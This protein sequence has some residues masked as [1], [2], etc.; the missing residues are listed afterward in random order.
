MLQHYNAMI[1]NVICF[2]AQLCLALVVQNKV[3]YYKCIAGPP[4][5]PM[6]A[7]PEKQKSP[8][9]ASKPVPMPTAKP[10]APK[11]AGSPTKAPVKPPLAQA[12]KEK[13]STTNRREELLKQLKAVEDAIA[14]KRSKM[15]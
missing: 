15:Q 8:V 7:K 2:F 14:R 4:V 6:K 1:I 11:P 10:V 12:A 13:K 5:K 9:V 3:I